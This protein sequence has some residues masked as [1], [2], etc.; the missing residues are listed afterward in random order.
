MITQNEKDAFRRIGEHFGK[1]RA[2]DNKAMLYNALGDLLGA[3]SQKL[4]N[5]VKLAQDAG[6]SGMYKQQL[7]YPDPNFAKRVFAVLDDAGLTEKAA[8][9]MIALF[10]TLCGL[11][12]PVEQYTPRPAPAPQPYVRPQP[13][14]QPNPQP[15]VKPQPAPQPRNQSASALELEGIS[16]SVYP[17]NTYFPSIGVPSKKMSQYLE[18]VRICVYTDHFDIFQIGRDGM[19][20][21]YQFVTNPKFSDFQ[22]IEKARYSC[23]MGSYLLTTK[24]EHIWV[25]NK[26]P[27]VPSS[28]FKELVEV[29]MQ[30]INK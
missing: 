10:D 27:S 14:P 15:E 21:G 26:A 2:L 7:R 5:Q 24:R 9:D 12:T 29:L 8:R 20:N 4:R 16:I 28:K 3:D 22:K 1:E 23:V 11:Q 19:T 17:P 18:K 30:K 25:M 13:A 6:L